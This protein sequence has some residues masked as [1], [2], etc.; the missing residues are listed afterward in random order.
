M[1]MKKHVN[2]RAQKWVADSRVIQ[3]YETSSKRIERC[4]ITKSAVSVLGRTVLVVSSLHSAATIGYP[5]SVVLNVT[6]LFHKDR[7]WSIFCLFFP[8]RPWSSRQLPGWGGRAWACSH[9]HQGPG[10]QEQDPEHSLW[11]RIQSYPQWDKKG[12]KRICG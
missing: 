9:G 7:L 12:H 5:V 3:T 6:L 8:R 4:E 10:T 1:L 2:S 11:C